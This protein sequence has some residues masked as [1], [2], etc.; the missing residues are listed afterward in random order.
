MEGTISLGPT[1]TAQILAI[2]NCDQLLDKMASCLTTCQSPDASIQ[3]SL[4][5]SAQYNRQVA[6]DNIPDAMDAAE[7]FRPRPFP[8]SGDTVPPRGPPLAWVLLWKGKYVNKYG[9]Y[10]P[11]TLKAS[12]WIVWDKRRLDSM[13]ASKPIAD[14][15]KKEPDLVEEIARDSPWLG[16]L[17]RIGT[18]A[19]LETRT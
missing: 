15:W 9:E 19:L 2:N 18:D 14:Q 11:E 12:G 10:V 5:M 13:G 4:S 7:V 3:K 17:V 8:F 1:I 16:G 6:R